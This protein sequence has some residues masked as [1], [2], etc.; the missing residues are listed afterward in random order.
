MKILCIIP[1]G[2][3]KI[4]DKFPN[5]GTR[6]A[7]NTYTG[8]FASKC[9]QYAEEFYPS[10]WCILSAKYGFLFPDDIVQG[11]YNVS[12]ND[13]STNPISIEE[14]ILQKYEKGLD[15]FEKIIVFGGKN[16]REIIRNVFSDK[17][18]HCPLEK[19]KN[20]MQMMGALNSS[21]K[22]GKLI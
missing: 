13:K 4:W 20:I 22:S 5:A 6:K 14:L 18:I 7:R 12:F 3:K 8:P 16:Y 9:R 1:C 15:V 21:I 11:P 10:L 17:N 2:S 19:S